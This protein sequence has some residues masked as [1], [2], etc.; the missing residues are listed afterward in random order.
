MLLIFLVR[1][2]KRQPS[3]RKYGKVIWN[4]ILSPFGLCGDSLMESIAMKVFTIFWLLGWFLTA[5]IFW[6]EMSSSLTVSKLHDEINSFGDV[7]KS[8]NDFFWIPEMQKLPQKI[9]QDLNLKF[10]KYSYE[11]YAENQESDTKIDYFN[12]KNVTKKL[13]KK[14]SILLAYGPDLKMQLS[15][16]LIKDPDLII[17][18]DWSVPHTFHYF[19]PKTDTEFVDAMNKFMLL[20]HKSGVMEKEY[21]KWFNVN[22]GANNNNN[23]EASF[24]LGPLRVVMITILLGSGLTIMTSLINALC[25]R[26]KQ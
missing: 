22:R 15:D 3:E 11:S 16:D 14:K 7:L 21:K 18:Y 24:E 23:L 17:K 20:R 1:I 5:G 6:A 26:E 2:E 9:V 12:L 25:K 8:N 19:L 10:K 13:L 4:F